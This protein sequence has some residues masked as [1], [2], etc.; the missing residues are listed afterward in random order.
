MTTPH[1]SKDV[2]T[3]AAIDVI[4]NN[5]EHIECSVP[6]RKCHKTD[7]VFYQLKQTR[8]GDEAMTPFITCTRCEYTF[9]IS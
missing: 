5:K 9:K 3:T 2:L 4:L 8:G 7:K 6:C 1:I